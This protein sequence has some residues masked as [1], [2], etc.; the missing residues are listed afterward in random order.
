VKPLTLIL[1]AVSLGAQNL[2]PDATPTFHTGTRLVEV[3]VIVQ[4]KKGAVEGL[5]KSD[6]TVLDNGIPQTIAIF[7]V[8]DIKKI[9]R[10]TPLPKKVVS[11][12]P[13]NQEGEPVAGTVVLFDRL[14]TP[15]E[16]QAYA[17]LQALKYIE[18]TSRN[19]Q[20]AVYGLNK[21]LTVL[22]TFTDDRDLLDKAVNQS[23]PELSVD[24]AT[25]DL[26]SGVSDGLFARASN[27]PQMH[28]A[29]ETKQFARDNRERITA[30]AFATIARH[31]SGLPGRKKL[32]WITSSLPITYTEARDYNGMS[33]IEYQ[34]YGAEMDR[35]IRALND[36][37]IGVY[38]VDPKGV[39][40]DLADSSVT[41]ALIL[42]HM[43]GGK[44]TYSNNDLAGAI[45]TVMTDTDLTYTLGFYPSVDR[46]DGK[47]HTVVV[48]V[49]RPDVEVRSRRGYSA[50]LPAKP[51]TQARRIGFLDAWS[52]EPLEA[53]DISV[54]AMANR[55]SGRPGYYAVEVIVDP[56]E[57]Q[58]EQK[59]GRWTGSFDLGIV[60]DVDHK[61]KGLQ[62]TI[63]VNLTEKSYLRAV[64]AGIVVANPIKVT[65]VKGSLLSKNLRLVVIDGASG[66]AGSVRIPIGQQ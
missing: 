22:Q 45:E 8:R 59:N 63:R 48:R 65:D 18:R 19:E 12:R 30:A 10:P 52:Q 57:L 9:S 49:N 11:N 39:G 51:L 61:I 1:L 50:S 17:R 34:S 66:K 37:N 24:L 26:V 64:V 47:Y 3:D 62:Q 60:P 5:T 38:P 42:A 15:P 54:H 14:N 40:V 28:G 21:K 25:D 2:V 58:L 27:N 16:D 44:A 46:L 33:T 6:F 56:T 29:Q 4:N 31:L 13:V 41:S 43:T 35:S 32:V 20:I 53:T 23:R 36:A 55:I 7:S